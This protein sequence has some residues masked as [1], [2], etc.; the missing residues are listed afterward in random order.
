MFSKNFLKFNQVNCN[1]E[2]PVTD[3]PTVTLEE[4]EVRVQLGADLRLGCSIEAFPDPVMSWASE[5]NRAVTK[6]KY[7]CDNC[8]VL[9]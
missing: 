4:E 8:F 2:I 5:D 6:G 9:F 1:N 3:P 7:E